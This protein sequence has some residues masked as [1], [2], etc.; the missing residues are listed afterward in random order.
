MQEKQIK[1][2]AGEQKI[3][4]AGYGCV[5]VMYIFS[6]LMLLKDIRIS[7]ILVN[8]TTVFYFVVMKGLDKK[9]NRDF[10]GTS[11][12]ILCEKQMDEV[13]VSRK[14]TITSSYLSEKGL[15]PVRTEGGGTACGLSVTGKR[16]GRK[17]ELCDLT[18][19]YN[20]ASS[21][22]K[23]KVGLMTGV[24]MELE[25]KEKADK[26]LVLIQKEA[27]EA[28]FSPSFYEQQGLRRILCSNCRLEKDYYLF[29]DAGTKEAEAEAFVRKCR[30]LMD[31][32]QKEE[33]RLM[34]QDT[35]N[36]I[37]IFL[38]NKNLIFDTPIRGKLTEPMVLWDR[39]PELG[40]AFQF[41]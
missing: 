1:K 13:T 12:K 28:H 38:E 27:F 2:L 36:S 30:K 17:T 33:C 21:T 31:R 5:I 6:I 32:T 19:C 14:G 26:R 20:R 18:V 39:I 4:K 25:K 15:F 9:Y 34:I 35:G 40:M 22:N 41:L 7:V 11:M 37:C 23:Q 8:V 16:K 29:A 10:A 24:W 3:L